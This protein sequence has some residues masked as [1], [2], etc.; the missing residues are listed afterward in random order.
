MSCQMILVV[1]SNADIREAIQEVLESEGYPV[2][3]S[4]HA[5]DALRY[6]RS[7]HPPCLVLLDMLS[8]NVNG[9]EFL[10]ARQENDV[11]IQIPVAVMSS[12]AY[13]NEPQEVARQGGSQ[14]LRKPFDLDKLLETV[15]R[16]CGHAS[17]VG[18]LSA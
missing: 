12:T 17:D 18:R 10:K 16:F 4:P 15:H 9:V 1:E 3:T 7:A 8:Q 13:P 11:L 5:E 2:T 6:L 14:Y